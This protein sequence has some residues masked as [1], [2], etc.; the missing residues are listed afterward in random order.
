MEP[1]LRVLMAGPGV[2]LQDSGRQGYLRFGV[3]PAGPMDPLAF[4]TANRALGNA[5]DTTAIEVGLGGL[6]FTVE[7]AA[8]TV[9]IAGGDFA[10]TLDGRRV[11]SAV[12]LR[13]EVGSTVKITA[14][15]AGAWCYVAIAGRLLVSPMLGSTATHTRSGFGGLDGK[16]LATGD[17]LGIAEPRMPEAASG[18]L[19]A[20]WLDR[21]SAV[22]RVVLGPQDDYF[23]PDQVSAFLAGP[24]TVSTKGDRMAYFL[25]GPKLRHEEGFNI[26][27]DGVAM[28]AIQVPGEGQ[29]IVLMADRQPTGG[30][31]KIA[32]VIGADLGRLAQARAGDTI[33]FEAVTVETAVAVR[34]ADMERLDAG[35]ACTPLRRTDFS[36]AF[37]LGLNLADGVV[38]KTALASDD[39]HALGRLTAHE[40]LDVLFDDATFDLLPGMVPSALIL[41]AGRADGRRVYAASRDITVRG[42]ALTAGDMR[43]L[44]AFVERATAEHAPIV[45]LCDGAALATE[46]NAETV[47]A[48]VALQS[49]FGQAGVPRIAVALGACIGPDALLA[50]LADFMIIV[51]GQG[52]MASGGPALVQTVTNEILTGP[53][54]GGAAIHAAAASL[55][56]AVPHDIAALARVRE[57]LD[58]MPDGGAVV[59]D[60]KARAAPSLDRL[61]PHGPTE[62][63]DVREILFA[64]A[65]EGAFVEIAAEGTAHVVI[66]FMRLGGSSVGV[67]ANQPSVLGGVLDAAA[68]AKATRFVERCAALSIPLLTVVDCPGL[69]PGLAQEK[70][71]LLHHAAALSRVLARFPQPRLTL[72]TRNMTGQVAG[73]MGIGQGKIYRWPSAVP[74]I[75]ETIIP[76]ETRRWILAGFA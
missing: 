27:S 20:P 42:G 66:G 15:P 55:V 35:I 65:D 71:G 28:G 24:W 33:R 5:P 57:L 49:A 52:F 25:E 36:S 31:P 38:G 67:L 18:I 12:L 21:P 8:A 51:T 63:Y 40:R 1:V 32:T 48:M 64:I 61:V 17:R 43:D 73:L 34:R 39:R 45:L 75:G 74:D 41:A 7:T 47:A 44:A 56:D 6:E 3:T 4:A 46:E 69:L 13:L 9:A 50:A 70:A 19:E 16:A 54:I 68:L 76:H 59:P 29:P 30:Y 2:T 53:E 11:P 72:I 62:V 10:I 23:A 58:V 60:G 22:I 14:G 26:V 37:L